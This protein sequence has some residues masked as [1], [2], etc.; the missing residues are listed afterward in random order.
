MIKKIFIGLAVL[1][2][3]FVVVVSMQPAEY[4]YAA[5]K[6]VKGPPEVAYGVVSVYFE[7]YESEVDAGGDIETP[8]GSFE[9]LRVSTELTRTVGV[10][11]VTSRTQLYVSE[12]FGTVTSVTSEDYE[13]D[14]D[15]EDAAEVRRLSR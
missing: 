7:D 3:G 6:V 12:C 11:V 2:I 13:S 10:A 5:S 1:V 8:F 15:F 4:A 9:V 14:I